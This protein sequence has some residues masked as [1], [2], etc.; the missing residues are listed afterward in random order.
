MPGAGCVVQGWGLTWQGWPGGVGCMAAPV[1]FVGRED[2]LS[3]LLAAVGGDARLVLVVGDAGVGKTRFVGEGMARAAAAG[4][5]MVRGECLPLAEALPLLPVAAAL[6]E[7]ARMD[8]GGLVD[9]GLAATPAFVRQEV[10]RLLPGLGPGGEPGLGG[11]DEGWQRQR[12]FAAVAELLAAVAGTAGCR[13]GLVAEDVHWAD[14]ATLDFLTFLG[15]PADRGAVSVLVTCR[16]DE[17]PLDA[18]VAGW[19]A[20]VRG[21]AGV[22]EIRLGPLSRAEVAAQ[23]AALAGG[24]VPPGVVNELYARRRGTR[25]SPSSWWPRRW[26]ATGVAGWVFPQG[27]R[28]GW[29]NCWWP[30]PGGALA[31]RGR[32][33]QGWR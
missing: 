28:D 5:V 21:A 19:L 26:R 27:C 14:H 13:V 12:L 25:F 11:R 32:C 20:Q 29:R 7:L 15:R 16:S 31:T 33:W 6:G 24:P 17:A 2:E 30:G 8:G 22:E 1:A 10:G 9:A 23:A 18:Q 3:R 4:A